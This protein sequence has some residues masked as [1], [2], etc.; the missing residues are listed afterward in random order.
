MST[1]KNN[2]NPP[3]PAPLPECN[4]ILLV[5]AI[6]NLETLAILLISYFLE[7]FVQGPWII[8]L[9]WVEH[10]WFNQ[11]V[12]NSMLDNA[13]GQ[14][15]I[16]WICETITILYSTSIPGSLN[17][18]LLTHTYYIKYHIHIKITNKKKPGKKQ[19]ES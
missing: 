1:E 15:A 3:T 2:D 8:F 19:T 4:F 11:C 18:W 5:H 9:L 16:V 13:T 17:C 7:L 12:T 14:T 10:A 6:T